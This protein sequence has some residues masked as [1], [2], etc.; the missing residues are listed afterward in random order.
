MEESKFLIAKNELPEW[1]NYPES[2]L[3]IVEQNL[4]DLSPWHILSNELLKAK[5]EG[6]KERYPKRNLIPFARRY[7]NDD[8]ACWE[9]SNPESVVIIHDYASDGWERREIYES[10]W[11]WFRVAINQMIE[12]Q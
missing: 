11:D 5:Y 1:F 9:Q 3:K 8:V 6:L 2:F 12:F 7:D 10:F 4:I